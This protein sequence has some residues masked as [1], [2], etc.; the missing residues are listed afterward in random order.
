MLTAL[1]T[2]TGT[3]LQWLPGAVLAC[4]LAVAWLVWWWSGLPGSL[5]TALQWAQPWVGAL[6]ALQLQAPQASLRTGGPMDHLRWQQDGLDINAQ[7]LN[8]QWQLGRE[9]L[10]WQASV[11]SLSVDDQRPATPATSGAPQ[12]LNALALPLAV[13]GTLHIDALHLPALPRVK[14]HALDIQH[15]YD[16]TAQRHTLTAQAQPQPQAQPQAPASAPATP[17]RLQATV[18]ATAPHTLDATLSLPLLATPAS[19]APSVRLQ[20]PLAGDDARLIAQLDMAQAQATVSLYP[21]HTQPVGELH[22]TLDGLNLATLLPGL[23]TTHLTGL[24]HVNPVPAP[25]SPSGTPPT[26]PQPWHLQVQLRNPEA[27]PW[28]QQRLP[29]AELTLQAQGHAQAGQ[30]SQLSA[31]VAEGR[32]SGQGQWA[33]PVWQ[34]PSWQGRWRLDGLSTRAVWSTWPALALS[35]DLQA[36]RSADTDPDTPPDTAPTSPPPARRA[37]APPS[38]APTRLT[39][40]LRAT[41]SDSTIKN[42]SK[43]TNQIKREGQIFSNILWSP[44]HISLSHTR[45]ALG[46]AVL[47]LSAQAHAPQVGA[48]HPASAWTVDGQA[49]LNLPGLS[50][51]GQWQQLA[52]TRPWSAPAANASGQLNVRVLQAEAVQ[53]WLRPWLSPWQAES[54]P[55]LDLRGQAGLDLR[56]QGPQLALDLQSHL[57]GQGVQGD[58]TLAA[59]GTWSSGS[60][61]PNG[62][63]TA[64]TPTWQGRV[65]QLVL[66][67]APMG[68][69]ANPAAPPSG[70]WTL[71]DE[72][73]TVQAA[74]QRVQLGA[75]RLLWQ[76]A[77]TTPA[78]PAASVSW[79]GL[80]WEDGLLSTQGALAHWS[81]PQLQSLLRLVRGAVPE[82][83]PLTTASGDL[84][85]G[86]PW[87]VRWPTDG[88]PRPDQA[89][90]ARWARESGDLWWPQGSGAGTATGTGPAQAV[91]LRTLEAAL[92][93]NAQGVS[94]QLQADSALLGQLDA[95]LN[96]DAR[97]HADSP[98]AGRITL[99]LPDL[100]QWSHW[101]PPGWRLQGQAQLV[102]Q[103]SGR[104]MHPLWQGELTGQQLG[105]RSAVEGLSYSN[106]SLRAQLN[107]QRLT[108][109]SFSLQG[110][111][112][113]ARGGRLD[114]SGHVD[115]PDLSAPPDIRLEAQA[116][117][118]NVSARADQRLVLSGQVWATWQGPAPGMPPSAEARAGL[119]TLRGQLKADQVQFTLPDDTAPTQG[120]DVVVRLN[121]QVATPPP[122][123]PAWQTDVDLALDL[124]PACTVQGQGLSTQLA[125]QLRLTRSPAQP[126]LRVVGEV[127]TVRGSYR[128]YG[129]SL[130]IS[131]GALRFNGP[132]DDPALDILALR[133]ASRAFERSGESSQQVGVK[134]T[135]S[136]RQ[137][138]VQLYAQ[139]DLPDSDKLAWLLL[140]RPATGVGAE[141]AVLQQAAMAMLAGSGPGLDG[142]LARTLGLDDVTLRTATTAAN[143]TSTD[144]SLLLGKRLSS[145]LYVAYEQSLSGTLSAISLFYDVS[146][147]LTLRARA[148]QAQSID[149]IAT[150]PHD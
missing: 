7:G 69:G 129:Q 89:L 92:Q 119:L 31:R 11:R 55:P 10:R 110:A 114:V 30:L 109:Q 51:Q 117:A 90:S 142:R 24:A 120:S 17:Y 44:E 22:A 61:P 136:A 149:L 143:G 126:S 96:T 112:G 35:G 101:A 23:P 41:P 40:D 8:V 105:L 80:N 139:P 85:L 135:G 133:P 77:L 128:A 46:G 83:D 122:A 145:R 147:R 27:G 79:Q 59:D 144:A 65:R 140:G 81:L 43:D 36:L 45:L 48:T 134:I 64:A 116:H 75:G 28:D 127:R 21:W 76:G 71:A 94:A 141:A 1:V 132:H 100:S 39:V 111:G 82:G 52:L 123:R 125:G 148:G 84:T 42:N 18:D 50:A 72:G 73:L 20:G 26:A 53:A 67:L 12:A 25:P 13:E 99:T 6:Q 70:R 14:L 49:D 4:T 62:V 88:R 130:T 16:T 58:L 102:T 137:P 54:T 19:P 32:V 74:P 95:T 5:N 38:T 9:G 150:L 108:L 47:N 2:A 34:A 63:A 15:R 115:W 33:G 131:E 87:S 113:E 56:W 124:G 3:A 118:L 107:G 98:L 57:S 29:L 103:L 104:L 146:R 121:H 66:S 68:A 78:T 91:G 60:T 106:G 86:G 93:G 97:L 37:V 138:R